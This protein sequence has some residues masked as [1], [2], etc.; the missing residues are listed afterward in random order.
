[1]GLGLQEEDRWYET[2]DVV[3][4]GRYDERLQRLEASASANNGILVSLSDTS[5]EA[6]QQTMALA[7]HALSERLTE[8]TTRLE[9]SEERQRDSEAQLS[10]LG[11]SPSQS[12]RRHDVGQ[13]ISQRIAKQDVSLDTPVQ[14]GEWKVEIHEAEG[15]GD[16]ASRLQACLSPYP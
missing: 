16:L 14:N 2:V 13:Y 4:M 10:V 9:N 12:T 15:Y 11:R 7:I 5:G 6:A 1:M 3:D 8:I